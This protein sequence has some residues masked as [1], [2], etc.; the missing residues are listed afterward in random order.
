MRFGRLLPLTY[1]ALPLLFA[2]TPVG[3]DGDWP[4]EIDTD[5]IHLVIYQPQVNS[6]KDN[7]IEARSAVIVT[8]NEDPAQS[9]GTVSIH[10]RAEI[11]RETRLVAFEDITVKDANIPS[12]SSLQSSLLKTLRESIPAWPRT[13]SLDCVLADLAIT[14]AEVQTEPVR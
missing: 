8:R 5:S 6:W 12:A 7:R 4:R 9:F 14:Q 10:A 11:D 13:V 3:G 1:I 2:Q